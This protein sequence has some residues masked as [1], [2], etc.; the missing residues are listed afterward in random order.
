MWGQGHHGVVAPRRLPSTARQVGASGTREHAPRPENLYR[1]EGDVSRAEFE[2]RI[3]AMPEA[4][5]PYALA[6]YA[7]AIVSKLD[8]AEEQE[9]VHSPC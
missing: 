4:H 2:A 8:R 5:R 3:Q 7:N 9:P 1:E 6:I